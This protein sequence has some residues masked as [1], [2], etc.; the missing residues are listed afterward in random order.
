MVATA[1]RFWEKLAA[2]VEF[3]QGAFIGVR[4]DKMPL[5]EQWWHGRSSGEPLKLRFARWGISA[6]DAD[7]SRSDP[8]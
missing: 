7:L 2:V 1:R 8:L 6:V 4:R 5:V 3:K